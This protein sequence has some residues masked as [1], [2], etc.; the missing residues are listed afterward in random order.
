MKSG[1]QIL[2][3][4]DEEI[5]RRTV[6]M[7]LEHDGHRVWTVDSGEA[8]LDQLAG[9]EFDLLITDIF[10]PGLNGRQLI[11]RV[12]QLLPAQPIIIATAFLEESQATGQTAENF[13]ALLLKPFS[14]DDLRA[15]I[16]QALSTKQMPPPG[17]SLP[18][19]GL[20]LPHVF[21]PPPPP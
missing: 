19:P 16:E 2:V 5:V 12:R 17:A 18:G 1:L 9:R 10:M 3:V 14:L 8:A 7:L 15:A 20:A 11:A 4:D 13:N 21:I 6:K